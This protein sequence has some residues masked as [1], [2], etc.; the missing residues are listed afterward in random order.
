MT[1]TPANTEVPAN[2]DMGFTNAFV[3]KN[4]K[5]NYARVSYYL[6][7]LIDFYRENSIP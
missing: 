3:T 4:T 1:R 5:E 6:L 2:R 7:I